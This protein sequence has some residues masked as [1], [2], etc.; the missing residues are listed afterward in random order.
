LDGHRL[1][2]LALRRA[3]PAAPIPEDLP[4]GRIVELPGRGSTYV[5]DTGPRDAPALVLLHALSCTGL[6]A[7]YPAIATLSQSHRVIVLDQRWHG[8][9]IRGE[10]FSFEDCA[11][12]AVAL[13]DALGIDKAIPVGY[14][15]GG[16]VAQL[17]WHRHPERVEGLVLGATARNFRG[18]HHERLFF[19]FL[20]FTT[21]CFGTHL[22]DRIERHAQR[23]PEVVAGPGHPTWGVQELRSTSGWAIPAVLS[24]LGR[25]NS[26]GW[27]AGVDVPTAVVITAR[28]R[29]I[30]ARR[31]RALAA[32]IPGAT[33]H[34]VDGG[35]AALVLKA[36][37]L[38][39]ALEEAC[40]SVVRRSRRVRSARRPLRV[41]AR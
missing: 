15:M 40:A 22:A 17:I 9:G 12:D 5:V 3:L 30:P 18:K 33:V 6:L 11:D 8:R 39:P 36:A 23:R 29:T 38:V 21:E 32:S 14:S 16:S 13:L 19:P 35:H 26:A 2:T 4:A 28:D 27:I 31:Q 1:A 10:R 24:A 41:N 25:F 7:W 34:E 20:S 37:E